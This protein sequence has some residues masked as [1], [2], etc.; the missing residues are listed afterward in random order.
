M[1]DESEPVSAVSKIRNL[2]V[3]QAVVIL[4]ESW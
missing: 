1:F 2:C 3:L 4:G